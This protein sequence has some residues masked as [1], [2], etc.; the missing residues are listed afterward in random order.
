M[1]KL[2]FGS[3]VVLVSLT[4]NEFKLL[5]DKIHSNVPDGTDVSL[6]SVKHKLDLVDAKQAELLDLKNLS[7]NVVSKLNAIGI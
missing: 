6:T 2:A 1:I 4:T 3:S 5:A 7:T